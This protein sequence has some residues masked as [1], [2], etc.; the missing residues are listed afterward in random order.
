MSATLVLLGPQRLR[1]TL[2]DAVQALGVAGQVATV[3][4]GWEE[5]E[6]EDEELDAHLDGRTVNLGLF[7][8]GELVFKR[9][10]QVHRAFLERRERMGEL[11][12]VF[13]PRLRVALEAAREL[14][15]RRAAPGSDGA[16]LDPEIEHAIGAVAD[17]DRHHLGRVREVDERFEDEARLAERESVLE[18][19]GEVAGLLAGTEMLAIAG[20]HVGILLN[21]LRLFDVLSAHGPRPVVAWSAGAMALTGRVVLFHDSPPQGRGDAEVY[22]PGLGLAPG[23]VALPHARRRLDLED[24]ARVELLARRF[25]PDLCVAMDEGARLELDGNGAWTADGGARVLN[26]EGRP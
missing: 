2:R 1:P 25:A 5:R 8:R 4:A 22:G 18:Q 3:T 13:R 11:A 24:T 7:P 14:L 19:R 17:L 16:L 12:A 6:G 10:P 21:R 15:R 9:D 26:A 20:G 23:L